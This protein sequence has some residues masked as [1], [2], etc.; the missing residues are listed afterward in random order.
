MSSPELW[1]CSNLK[2]V[3]GVRVEDDGGVADGV[4]RA[5]G[6]RAED[7]EGAVQGNVADHQVGRIIG[8]PLA[9]VCRLAQVTNGEEHNLCDGRLPDD[10]YF[11][12]RYPL[13]QVVAHIL[14]RE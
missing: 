11:A 14:L 8:L 9:V 7:A 13:R 3:A 4:R 10:L 1:A 6:N 5:T 2:L 12:Q